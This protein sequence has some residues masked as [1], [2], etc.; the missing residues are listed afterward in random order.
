MTLPTEW[1]AGFYDAWGIPSAGNQGRFQYTGQA[2]ILELGMYYYKARFYS[3]MLGRFMQTDPI[4]Y[5][6]GINLYAYVDNDPSNQTDPDGMEA[7]CVTLNR[8]C[9]RPN[10]NPFGDMFRF[11][12]ED[13]VRAFREPSVRNVTIAMIGITPVGRALTRTFGAV[14]ILQASAAFGSAGARTLWSAAR[15]AVQGLRQGGGRVFAS[16]A[17][18]AG[19]R[20]HFREAGS[21]AQRFGGSPSDYQKVSTGTIATTTEGA[22]IEVHAVRNVETGRLY[23]LKYKIQGGRIDPY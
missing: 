12:T 13:L 3:P 4:G 21:F 2:W 15:P 19:S 5:E 6:G 16:G 11:F 10:A 17:I 9:L 20:G 23:D 22:K 18:P 1:I 7:P 8:A 14:R